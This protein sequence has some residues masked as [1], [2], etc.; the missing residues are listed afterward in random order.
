MALTTETDGFRIHGREVYWW[1]R[2][3]PGTSPRNR[4]LPFGTFACVSRPWFGFF[5]YRD[6]RDRRL[7]ASLGH[8]PKQ[9]HS[10]LGT[11]A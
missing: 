10:R 1:R 5:D 9:G 4:T 3:K 11:R 6:W 7:L 8:E 2:K